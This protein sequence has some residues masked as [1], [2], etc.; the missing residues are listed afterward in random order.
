MRVTADVDELIVTPPRQ[1]VH[2]PAVCG[3]KVSSLARFHS[4]AVRLQLAGAPMMMLRMCQRRS[5]A[6]L[7]LLAVYC[8]VK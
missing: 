2:P 5:P 1:V 8:S 3:P 4:S 6:K 7:P